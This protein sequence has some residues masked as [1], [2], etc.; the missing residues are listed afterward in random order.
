[1]W[2]TRASIRYRV[3]RRPRASCAGSE[4]R[5]NLHNR[6]KFPPLQWARR[7][8][9][10]SISAARLAHPAPCAQGHS[11]DQ[12]AVGPPRP[13][14]PSRPDGPA[15]VRGLIALE[16]D[17]SHYLLQ[18]DCAPRGRTPRR[19]T[20]GRAEVSTSCL[21]VRPGEF[22]NPFF[23]Y[24]RGIPHWQTVMENLPHNSLES[25]NRP[26]RTKGY[27]TEH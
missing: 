1:M 16:R 18:W 17:A 12:S 13:V 9:G 21:P 7:R 14:A 19:G 11:P 24:L 6:L 23:H 20:S 2:A 22:L 3:G 10:S 8:G 26:M 4:R 25:E 27:L 15:A 5:C